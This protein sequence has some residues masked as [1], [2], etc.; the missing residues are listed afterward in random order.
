MKSV[1]ARCVT[2]QVIGKRPPTQ[3][4]GDL[5]AD[6]AEIAIPF[7][8]SGLDG[9]GFYTVQHGRKYVK[10]WVLMITCFVTRGVCLLPLK[11]MSTSTVINA[12]VRMNSQFPGLKKVYC[13]N[14]SNFVGAKRELNEAIEAWN[15]ENLNDRLT[16]LGIEWMFGPAR[17][18]SAG[19]VWE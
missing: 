1:L 15:R 11:D 3:R 2:C 17:C 5:P 10:R 18:G 9:F 19:G 4:L 14:G 13:D 6:C 12:L 7:E 16:D 8:K